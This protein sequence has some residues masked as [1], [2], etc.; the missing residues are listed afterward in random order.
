MPV[1]SFKYA[2][3]I[4][5]FFFLAVWL[6]IFWRA[7]N[8][9]KPMLIMSLITAAFGPISE[10]WY[11]ADYW[12]PEVALPLPIIGGVEDLLFGFSIGG[13][14]A[15]AYESLFVR[16][17]CKCEEKKLK[18]EWFL[19]VFFAAVGLSMI[20]LNNL[21]GLNSIFAS[22][23]GMIVVAAIML[24]IRPDL[25]TNA[26]G[27]AFLVAGIMFVIY[28]LGQEVFPGSHAW[29]LRI[30]KLSSTP[31]GVIILKHIPWTEML[32]GLSWGLV[33]GPMYEFLVGAR[34]ITFKR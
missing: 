29:M 17:I 9:R 3:L 23:I 1:T 25:I 18:R 2:Y 6:V 33:W 5:N 12:K 15:F 4:A 13:I 28:F 8:L 34:M 20:I 26:I 14:G 21:L 27:S 24:Y 32:W 30:W 10:L 19:F 11:F 7:K 31:K 22:S 16:G